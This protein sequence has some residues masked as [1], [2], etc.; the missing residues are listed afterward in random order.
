MISARLVLIACAWSCATLSGCAHSTLAGTNIP[1]TDD[2]RAIYAI[3]LDIDQ[4]MEKRDAD[5]ILKHVSER[6]FEDNGTARQ[7]DDYGYAELKGRILPESLAT[8]QEV[9]LDLLVQDIVVE[10]ERAHVDLR[11]NSRAR[12]NL[13]AGE[14]WDSHKDF[15]RIELLLEKGNWRIVS[16]L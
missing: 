11:Y 8:T 5:G 4:A 14:M 6:Y 13:P 3:V 16:G 2:T 1:D 10:G 7:E 15:N 9:Q 12:L